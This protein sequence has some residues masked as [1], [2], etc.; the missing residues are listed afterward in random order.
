MSNPNQT[1]SRKSLT[2]PTT[3]NLVAKPP[4]N[5]ASKAKQSSKENKTGLGGLPPL[6]WFPR[7]PQRGRCHRNPQNTNKKAIERSEEG[8][9]DMTKHPVID[10]PFLAMDQMHSETANVSNEVRLP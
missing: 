3:V 7:K 2:G 9:L 6:P 10:K 5:N 4:V 8:D 1:S